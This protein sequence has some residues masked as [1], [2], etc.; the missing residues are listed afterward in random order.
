LAEKN[1]QNDTTQGYITKFKF[2][3]ISKNVPY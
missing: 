2:H 3:S 1:K